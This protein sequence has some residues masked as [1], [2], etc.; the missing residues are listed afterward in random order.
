M[1]EEPE[2]QTRSIYGRRAR[3]DSGS[4]LF[5]VAVLLRMGLHDAFHRHETVRGPGAQVDNVDL[6]AGFLSITKSRPDKATDE[7]PKTAGSDREIKL[8]PSVAEI[9]RHI[10]PIHV[11]EKSYVYLNREGQP[12]NFRTWQAGVW[13]RIREAGVR[14]R[15]PY[16]TRHTFISVGLTNG[17]NPKWIADYCGT[18]VAMIEKHYGKYIRS[19]AAEQ[20]ARLT[21]TVPPQERKL[22]AADETIKNTGE[23]DKWAHLDSNQGPT[24]YEP[25]ALT[26]LSYGPV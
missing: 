10:K 11:P 4:V 9:L 22:I 14:E 13:Y 21:G 18:S 3:Q 12:L 26:K 20:L 6:R 15:K 23:I 16:C 17:V 2:T 25:V 7:S 8:L 1:A 5:E 24:G 19:D